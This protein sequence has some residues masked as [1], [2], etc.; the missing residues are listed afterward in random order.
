M[1]HLNPEKALFMPDC[2]NSSDDNE[3]L[4]EQPQVT[5]RLAPLTQVPSAVHEITVGQL[6][7]RSGKTVSAPHFYEARG[8]ISSR[9]TGPGRGG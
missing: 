6:P 4:S 3:M 9:R 1:T 2:H 8:L 5:L 7:A